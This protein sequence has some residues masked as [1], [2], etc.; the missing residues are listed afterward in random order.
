MRI[1]NFERPTIPQG[2]IIT[3]ATV[4][5]NYNVELHKNVEAQRKNGHT[6]HILK[7]SHIPESQIDLSVLAAAAE[8]YHI[9]PNQEDYILVSLP[10]VT[11]GVPNRNLQAFPEEEV[12][13]FDPT[14]GKLVYQTFV[15][16]GLYIDHDN[17]DP[18]KSLGLI[19]DASMNHIPKYDLWKINIMTLWDRTKDE[20]I[21]A[22]ILNKQR[23]GYSMGA[24]VAA[25][26]CSI[27][28]W[29]DCVSNPC[30]HEK[31]K[32]YNNKLAYHL[33]C[34]TTYFETSTVGEPAD[35]TAVSEDVYK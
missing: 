13:Y 2:H 7:A 3:G 32:I 15:G 27:C 9:S 29:S 33:C 4:T 26:S 11:V 30:P 20:K 19:V 21:V 12:F 17:Q 22:D 16:K 23:T 8:T 31:G 28:G 1:K 10:I 25:F 34:G 6:K 24:T 5:A 18:T 35:P 14:Q